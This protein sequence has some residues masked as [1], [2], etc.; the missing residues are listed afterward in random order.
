GTWSSL[1]AE[2]ASVADEL[3]AVLTAVQAG[4]WA[5]PSAEQYVTAHLPYLAW[6]TQASAASTAAA[7]QHETLAG[8]YT[9][10]LAAMPTLAELAANHTSHAVL[11]ATNFFGI[12]TIPIALNEADYVRMWIQAAAT[13]T[14]YQAVAGAQ[15]TSMP[16]ATAAPTI[17]K[18]DAPAQSSGSDSGDNPLGLPRWLVDALEKLGIGNTQLAH[19]PTISNP[20]N[21]FIA[22]VLKNFGI[23]WNPAQGTLNG[24]DYDVYTNPGQW[25]FWVARSLELLEDFEQFG[26]FLTQNPVQAFQWLISWQLF[27][28]PTHIL[29]V[30]NFLSQSPG[31]LA[32]A[33]G[34]GI[35]PA[36]SVGGLAGL[37]GLAGIPPPAIAALPVP[38][39][40]PDVSPGAVIAPVT[41]AVATPPAAAP[42]PA[43]A[44]PPA[45][46][47]A[48]PPPPP[49]PAVGGVGFF[50]PYLVPPGIG[51]GSQLGS[52]AS[53]SAKKKT[54]QTD[55]TAAAA[56]AEARRQA[57]RR[58]RRREMHR[59]DGDEYLDA[60]IDVDPEWGTPPAERR[61]RSPVMASDWGAGNLGFVSSGSKSTAEAAGMA[62][63]AGTGFSDRP[64]LP[65]MPTTWPADHDNEQADESRR[66]GQVRTRWPT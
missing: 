28:F 48:G 61:V 59:N 43:T 53:S 30:V 27:D 22:E 4:A 54:T 51:F 37:A 15:L 38:A 10:A 58:R 16:H 33:A 47:V 32:A 3:G 21:T 29:E 7:A 24:L 34:A 62:A 49:P 57:Q 18:S 50:P 44:A 1:S 17:L 64:Q 60:N 39:V 63:L 66:P 12:N 23:N 26:V 20:M 8:A 5:G 19:D 14:T 11:V 13:M 31:L 42:V 65:L 9:G 35:A 36:G 55:S 46:A 45:T 25:M 2:Y 41:S 56:A 52:P 40:V 6:L